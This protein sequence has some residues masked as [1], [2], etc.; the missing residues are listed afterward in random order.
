MNSNFTP[1]RK[2]TALPSQMSMDNNIPT[3]VAE[4]NYTENYNTTPQSPSMTTTPNATV[5]EVNDP[6]K[7]DDCPSYSWA[8]GRIMTWDACAAW[9]TQILKVSTFVRHCYNQKVELVQRRERVR[10]V[11][12]QLFFLRDS[13]YTRTFYDGTGNI[14]RFG[15]GNSLVV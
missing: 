5:V 8:G 9:W 3:S 15:C 2:L 6:K 14:S 7:N 10:I 4:T 12:S 13:P 11:S 1:C